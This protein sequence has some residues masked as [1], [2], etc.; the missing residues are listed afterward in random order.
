MTSTRDPTLRP[1]HPEN[2]RSPAAGATP[3]D[4]RG[5]ADQRPSADRATGTE[6]EPPG[7]SGSSWRRDPWKDAFLR[8]LVATADVAAVLARGVVA[9]LVAEESLATTLWWVAVLPLWIIVAKLHGLYDEDHVRIRHRT[10]DEIPRL[11]NWATVSTATTSLVL[12]LGPVHV[13]AATAVAGW[14]VAL[15]LGLLLRM[16]AR[17][18]WRRVVTPERGVVI[19]NGPLADALARKLALEPGHHLALV[20]SVVPGSEAARDARPGPGLLPELEA[21]IA[22]E[23]AERVVLA[24]QDV[25][26]PTLARVVAT[27]RA[28]GVKLS[29]APPVRAMLGTAVTLTHLAELPVIEF[30][31][32]DPSRSTVFLKRTMDIAIA[33][34]GM[35][36]LF[37]LLLLIAL[38]IRIDSRGPALFRQPRVGQ[39]GVAFTLLKFRTMVAN[40]EDRLHDLVPIDELPDPMFKLPADPRV[41]RVG[42]LLRRTSLDELPQLI[43]VLRGEMSLVGPRPEEVRLVQRYPPELMFR[44]EMRPGITGPMQVHGRGDLTFQERT[45]VEREYVENYSLEKD[46]KILLWTMTAV[47]RRRGAY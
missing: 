47:L 8:R 25:D 31:T 20:A 11:F 4:V 12:T 35:V 15:L 19:G 16:A 24:M 10:S 33:A 44:L 18:T 42:R 37:P 6:R 29:V 2:P 39:R 27:C 45:A 7:S 40:A 28:H 43:N 21:T 26:E 32:W 34:A 3:V 36:L 14:A 46:I 38:L 17:T 5:P 23:S 30:S 1:E 41:T 22:R 9:G 13:T